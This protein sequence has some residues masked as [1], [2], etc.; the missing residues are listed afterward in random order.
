[1]EGRL[2]RY[3]PTIDKA[4]AKDKKNVEV[5]IDMQHDMGSTK[6][7]RSRCPIKALFV[8]KHA[9]KY[10]IILYIWYQ[11][12][13]DLQIKGEPRRLGTGAISPTKLYRINV[14]CAHLHDPTV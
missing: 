9:V 2:R 12:W 6:V 13:A 8:A 14:S 1:M 10:L 5:E 11:A 7:E 3:P 4:N